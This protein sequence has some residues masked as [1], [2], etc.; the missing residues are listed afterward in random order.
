MIPETYRSQS[1]NWVTAGNLSN[2]LPD[3]FY[4]EDCWAW[5]NM[6]Q[7]DAV[8]A[9]HGTADGK[10][11]EKRGEK[12]KKKENERGRKSQIVNKNHKIKILQCSICT[13][14]VLIPVLVVLLSWGQTLLFTE[15]I[16]EVFPHCICPKMLLQ[17]LPEPR[18]ENHWFF[19]VE[20]K[21]QVPATEGMQVCFIRSF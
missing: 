8:N 15:R 21:E 11:K 19:L 3:A 5:P 17:P 13:H 20:L 14:K 1:Q 18:L 6:G 9:Y 16:V 4:R 7:R 2:S 10:A 12:I